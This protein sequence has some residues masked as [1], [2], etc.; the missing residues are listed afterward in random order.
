MDLCSLEC[1]SLA[2]E[3][4]SNKIATLTGWAEGIEIFRVRN[5]TYSPKHRLTICFGF[6]PEEAINYGLH[7]DVHRPTLKGQKLEVNHDGSS[8]E[9]CVLGNIYS[10]VFYHW[11]EELLKVIVLEKYGFKGY[12]LIPEGYP[13]FCHQSFSLLGVPLN[14]LR[15]TCEAKTYNTAYFTSTVSHFN[16]NKYPRLI[17]ALRDALSGAAQDR[18][19]A[20]ERD[21]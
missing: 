21:G 17:L 2:T 12:Y 7:L 13:E 11:V 8:D 15:A 18:V 9:V 3:T 1:R 5:V 10:H 19:G 16:A 14:R 4:H 6:V 20:G